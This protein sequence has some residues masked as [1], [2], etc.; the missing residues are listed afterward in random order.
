V[1]RNHDPQYRLR[2]AAATTMGNR[3]VQVIAAI[4]GW[5]SLLE[6]I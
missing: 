6:I 5:W 4:K 2:T 3:K 1:L